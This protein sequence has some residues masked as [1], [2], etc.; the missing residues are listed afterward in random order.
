MTTGQ[1][2][3]PGLIG[4]GV[5]AILTGSLYF[6]LVYHSPAADARS[7]PL[8]FYLVGPLVDES[9]FDKLVRQSGHLCRGY[10]QTTHTVIG[11]PAEGRGREY[12]AVGDPGDTV[13]W[14]P[15][16]P[17]GHCRIGTITNQP[18]RSFESVLP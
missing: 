16:D 5:L 17:E 10:H 9:W 2:L 4:I 13:V 18:L 1:L 11:V 3:Y 7:E 8:R 15:F 14:T 12:Y 6:A